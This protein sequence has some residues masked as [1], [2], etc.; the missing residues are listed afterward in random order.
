M[1]PVVVA[2]AREARASVRAH[3]LCKCEDA[4]HPQDAPVSGI[5]Q[6]VSSQY[7]PTV[8]HTLRGLEDLLR[9]KYDPLAT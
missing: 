1:A 5:T 7:A 8:G 3:N 6:L 2:A 9:V 4:S